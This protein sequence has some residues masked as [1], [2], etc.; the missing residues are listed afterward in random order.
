MQ[1]LHKFL[2]LRVLIKLNRSYILS[3]QKIRSMELAS[4]PWPKG[5]L[6]QLIPVIGHRMKFLMAIKDLESKVNNK[7]DENGEAAG[8]GAEL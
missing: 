4:S 6:Q 2:L 8:P 3:Q 7:E 1:K 5:A